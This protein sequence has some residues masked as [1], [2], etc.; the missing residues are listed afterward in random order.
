[1][2]S[3][4]EI[5]MMRAK[6]RSRILRVWL[7]RSRISLMS[8]GVSFR[9]CWLFVEDELALPGD[10]QPVHAPLMDDFDFGVRAEQ[11]ARVIATDRPGALRRSR[12]GRCR[13]RAAV[14]LIGPR[15]LRHRYETRSL[16]LFLCQNMALA[17]SSTVRPRPVTPCVVGVVESAGV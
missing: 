6:S 7:R 5:F 2:S 14:G 17:V 11:F 15:A 4:S 1:M 10:L 12:R 8:I 3:A 9:V 16:H 13:R